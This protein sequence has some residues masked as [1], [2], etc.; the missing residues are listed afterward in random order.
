MKT[1]PKK[2]NC[3]SDW[4]FGKLDKPSLSIQEVILTGKQ[5]TLCILI[6]EVRHIMLTAALPVEERGCCGQRTITHPGDVS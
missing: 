1:W 2:T 5:Q 4:L 3:T 6:P